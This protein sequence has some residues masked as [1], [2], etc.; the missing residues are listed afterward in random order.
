MPAG[1]FGISTEIVQ[2]AAGEVGAC[3]NDLENV[4]A[5][6]DAWVAQTAAAWEG[7]ASDAYVAAQSQW[8][9]AAREMRSLMAQVNATLDQVGS[10]AAAVEAAN[11]ARFG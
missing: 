3:G 4:L 9:Q 5:Q 1:I 11:Q 6:L 8:T 2:Q 10:E 7:Q